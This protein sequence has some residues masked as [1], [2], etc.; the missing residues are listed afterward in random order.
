M[1]LKLRWV[2]RMNC[3][4]RALDAMKASSAVGSHREPYAAA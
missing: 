3:P 1:A 2:W 4:R